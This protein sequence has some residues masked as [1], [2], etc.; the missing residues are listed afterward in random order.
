MK[1]LAF[2]FVV[3][4]VVGGAPDIA[5]Q[6]MFPAFQSVWAEHTRP[7]V[8]GLPLSVLA[9]GRRPASS[10]TWRSKIR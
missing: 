5:S 10:F 3:A 6:S 1:S 7:G 4:L 2:S 8:S 9:N